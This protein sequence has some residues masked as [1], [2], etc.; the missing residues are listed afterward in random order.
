MHLSVKNVRARMVEALISGSNRLGEA[1]RGRKIGERSVCHARVVGAEVV[2][3][4]TTSS[5]GVL[6]LRRM[7]CSYRSATFVMK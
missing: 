3:W 1:C 6:L 7:D 5:A 2:Q 4:D